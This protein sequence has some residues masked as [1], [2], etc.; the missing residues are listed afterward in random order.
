MPFHRPVAAF[1]NRFLDAVYSVQNGIPELLAI[2]PCTRDSH[3]NEG[4]NAHGNEQLRVDTLQSHQNPIFQGTELVA[5]GVQMEAE[6]VEDQGEGICFN[7]Y[8]YNLS[9]I[10][11]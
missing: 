11:I 2:L 6:S 10:H 5:R 7:V 4:D 3:S 9:L 1:F 8:V